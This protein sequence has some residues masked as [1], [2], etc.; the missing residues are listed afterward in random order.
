MATQQ[1]ASHV[2][3]PFFADWFCVDDEIF[4]MQQ[5][6]V[7]LYVWGVNMATHVAWH[8]CHATCRHVKSPEEEIITYVGIIL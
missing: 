2:I 1:V 7:M 4:C 6:C 8:L 3:H 5:I